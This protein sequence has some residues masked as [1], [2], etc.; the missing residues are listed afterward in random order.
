M[1]LSGSSELVFDHHPA[2]SDGGQG[3]SAVGRALFAV[4]Y[5]N[6]GELFQSGHDHNYQRLRQGDRTAR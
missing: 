5:Q 1:D 2:F 4:T 3:D 6:R